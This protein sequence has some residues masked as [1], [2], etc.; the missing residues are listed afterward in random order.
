MSQFARE[1]SQAAIDLVSDGDVTFESDR[2]Q[3][4]AGDLVFRTAGVERARIKHDGTGTGWSNVLGGSISFLPA[5]I[6][7]GADDSAALNAALAAGG[8]FAAKDDASYTIS[9]PIVVPSNTDVDFGKAT[10]TKKSGTT[11]NMLQNSACT[12]AATASDGAMT[13][14]GTT[15][16]TTLVASIGQTVI[17]SGA[18]GTAGAPGPLVANVTAVGTGTL[19]LAK[20]A[21]NTVSG[22]AVASFTRDSNI[23]VRGGYWV[24]GNLGSSGAPSWASGATAYGLH[25]ILLRRIDGLAVEDLRINNTTAGSYGI[26]VG[27]CTDFLLDKIR[28]SAT[29]SGIQVNGPA[30]D[31]VI[32]RVKMTTSDDIVALTCRDYTIDEDTQGD[33]TDVEINSTH[34]IAANSVCLLAGAGTSLLRIGVNGIY[35]T[36]NNRALRVIDDTSSVNTQGGVID[37]VTARGIKAATSGTSKVAVSSTGIRDLR[38]EDVFF[39][40]AVETSA[41]AVID[42]TGCTAESISVSGLVVYSLSGT[43]KV[44]T[45]GSATVTR[46]QINSGR[47]KMSG[48]NQALVNLGTGSVST[49]QVG[50]LEVEGTSSPTLIL[51]SSTGTLTTIQLSQVATNGVYWMLDL[52][53]TS[54]VYVEGVSMLTAHGLINLRAAANVV[55]HVGA[56]QSDGNNIGTAAGYQLRATGG[57]F[58]ADIS[59]LN[60]K[61]GGDVVDN[62]N[63]STAPY[64]TGLVVFDGGE[65]KWKPVQGH[66]KKGTA[67]LVAGTVTV[68]DTKVTASAQIVLSRTT[69]G[70]TTG[71]LS[72][73]VSAGTSFTINSSSGTDTSTVLYEILAY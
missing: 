34:Q 35:G 21:A 64:V 11:G 47:V 61:T 20:A 71:Q 39:D 37:G 15:L 57:D 17:V 18:G 44:V 63:A 48:S 2:D 30:S 55:L 51:A 70:G 62:S 56:F 5:P 8:S 43:M 13:A 42:L 14:S 68:S 12:A 69:T 4:G 28:G 66:A 6:G 54:T 19:T 3:D 29:S 41:S 72:Y 10:I 45:A 59:L 24:R 46:L 27:D 26:A 1:D 9:A 49:L 53:S 32:S 52:N 67:T 40:A 36:A 33:I 16:T 7:G 31:G 23:R 65:N 60:N 58:H 38:L 25:N 73:T 50:H 22:A